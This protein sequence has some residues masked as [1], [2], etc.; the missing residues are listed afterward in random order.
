MLK[1]LILCF[2]ICLM[3]LTSHAQ[4]S[5]YSDLHEKYSLD[6]RTFRVALIPGLSTN[7]L[8]ATNYASKYSLNILGGYNGAL[9]RGFELGGLLNLNKYYAHGGQ[10]AGLGNYSG[11][12][13]SGVQLAGLFNYSGRDMQ[14]IQLSGVLNISEQDM[15]GLQLTG[16]ANWAKDYAQG[17]QLSGALNYAGQDM[18]GLFFSGAANISRTNMQGLFFTGAV[19]YT[20]EEMQ[21]IAASGLLNYSA[22]MQ[23]IVFA[24]ININKEAQGIQIGNLNISEQMQGIQIGLVNYAKDMEGVPVGLISYYNNGRKNIDIWT[25]DA[26]F[27]NFGVKLGTDEVYNMV[28]IGYNPALNRDVWQLGWSIGRLHEY[29]NHFLFTDFSI[30][31][32]NE[33]NWTEDLNT[34]FKYRLQ[35]GKELGE[36]F[37]MYGGPTF[38]MLI[39]RVDESSDYTWYRIFDFGAKG[40]DYV[41]WIGYSFGIQ[42]F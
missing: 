25:S 3:A 2:S 26:G 30:F 19:N 9:D 29:R 42:L 14:G 16:L 10:I 22:F 23:G 17:I 11:R 18:Q 38:N 40:R 13:T 32:I 20:G 15:Q 36:G 12:E 41:F 21:G 24:P 7:G 27:T 1:N 35:F 6:Y 39:S 5:D 28:S 8:D 34:L 31:K 4:N 37:N 33:S